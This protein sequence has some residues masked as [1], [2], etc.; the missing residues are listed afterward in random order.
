MTERSLVL[1]A[2]EVQSRSVRW[3][4][5]GWLPIGYLTVAT[6]VEG[7][8]KSVLAA[9]LIARLTRGDLPGEWSGQPIDVLVVAS[10]DGISDTWRPRLE[11]ADA[12][13]EKVAFLD[14]SALPTDWNVRDG[15][16][17][18]REAIDETGAQFVHVDALLDQM[19]SP[20]GGESVNS[21]TFVRQ[22]LGPLKA[23]VRELEIA[24]EFGLHPPKARSADYRDLVQASQAFSAIPRVGLLVAY[25]PGDDVDDPDR[26]RVVIRGKG[27]L[28][29]DPGALEFHVVGRA[30]THGDG[31]TTDREVVVDVQ[32]SA[33]NL[34]DLAPDRTIGTLREPSKTER[35]TDMLRE[36]LAD[37]QRHPAG[38]IRAQLAERRLGGDSVVRNATGIAGVQKQKQPHANGAWEWWIP[39]SNVAE[40]TMTPSTPRARCLSGQDAFDLSGDNPNNQAKA[41]RRPDPDGDEGAGRRRPGAEGL[42]ARDERAG[43]ER[44][45]GRGR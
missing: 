17:Q 27:N 38:V 45:S 26:R 31:R 33:I 28:G 10:E 34:A 11:L 41:S 7:L 40:D 3:A 13:L 22:A 1:R 24:V 42:R 5:L 23:L 9:W 37:G 12:D 30:L 21:P 25:H 18:L 2:S 39:S 20:R 32:P 36:L 6:G 19:P 29:R 35:A 4:W 16:E 15:I 14:L 8:G 43:A 44:K